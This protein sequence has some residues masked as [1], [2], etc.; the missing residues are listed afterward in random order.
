VSQLTGSDGFS[1]LKDV[2]S[3]M[4]ER[5]RI[6]A[7]HLIL[8]IPLTANAKQQDEMCRNAVT[9]VA[10]H[11]K[12]S[13]KKFYSWSPFS[14]KRVHRAKVTWL[15]NQYQTFQRD[16]EIDVNDSRPCKWHLLTN[17]SSLGNRVEQQKV[18]STPS[19]DNSVRVTS[20][21]S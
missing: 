20:F 2:K 3:S 1:L 6:D 14:L 8:T 16:P 21:R 12:S 13:G 17:D 10:D 4:N 11:L 7:K 5:R 15:W 9:L 18:G 19:Q